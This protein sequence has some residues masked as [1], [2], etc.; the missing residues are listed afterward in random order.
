MTAWLPNVVPDGPIAS[1]WG[2]TIRD[3]TVTPFAN[4]AART[5]AIPTPIVGQMS[6]LIDRGGPE[7]YNGTV[8]KALPLGW[9]TSITIPNYSAPTGAFGIPSSAFTLPTLNRKYAIHAVATVLQSGYT[10]INQTVTLAFQV[11]AAFPAAATGGGGGAGFGDTIP[12][13]LSGVHTATTNNEG[14][15]MTINCVNGITA[16]VTQAK[17]WIEDI[18]T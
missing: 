17:L 5:T 3:R 1:T 6:W 2:N 4:A 8:W 15:S 16:Q 10:N 7:I 11:G 9:I 12:F 18:G 13:Y 14:G